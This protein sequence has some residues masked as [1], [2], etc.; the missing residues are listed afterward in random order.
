MKTQYFR[1]VERNLTVKLTAKF[2]Y[3]RTLT[4]NGLPRETKSNKNLFDDI[5]SNYTI[6]PCSQIEY[7]TV[8]QTKHL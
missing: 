8:N 2:V 7:L 3:F 4:K 5:K 1:I 6:E